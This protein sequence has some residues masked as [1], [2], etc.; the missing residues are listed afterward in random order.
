MLAQLP[1]QL[2]LSAMLVLTACG[3]GQPPTSQGA[4]PDASGS[5]LGVANAGSAD[6]T[7][8][9]ASGP[10]AEIDEEIRRLEETQQV[11][12]TILDMFTPKDK[13]RAK[14]RPGPA[15]PPG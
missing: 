5:V 12:N 10:F 15:K 4:Q 8:G 14:D 1:T 7:P 2:T 13:E 9:A 6:H 3:G 11:L